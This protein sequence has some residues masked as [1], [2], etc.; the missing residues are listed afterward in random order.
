VQRPIGALCSNN[1]KQ[2]HYDITF[3]ER[4]TYTGPVAAVLILV[5][6]GI[7]GP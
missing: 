1:L 5:L 4:Y 2:R 3:I 7:F 6:T